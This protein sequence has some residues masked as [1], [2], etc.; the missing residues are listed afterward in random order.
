MDA[1]ADTEGGAIINV[2]VVPGSSSDRV[3]GMLG[4]ALKVHVSVP[5]QKGR[6]NLR[7]AKILAR[8]LGVRPGQVRLLSGIKSRSKR[9]LVSKITAKEAENLLSI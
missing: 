5:A 9:F 8:K 3:A 2:K 4:G 7:V 6:A 1:I